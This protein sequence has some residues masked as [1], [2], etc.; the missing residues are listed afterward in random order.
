MGTP[1][2]AGADICKYIPQRKPIVMIDSFYG[3][4]EEQG[5]ATSV[6]GLTIGEDNLFVEDGQ[7]IDS[8]IIEHIAQ[9]G[10]M[11]IGYDS[12]SNGRPVPL[13][14]IGSVN[15]LTINR[16]PKVGETLNTTIV[17]EAQVGDIT[18]IGA[19]VKIGD[20]TIASGK[21]KVATK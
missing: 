10:A 11:Q 5:N 16:L 4:S 18:L 1:V 9:S 6:S 14:F 3:I 8:G 12:I 20:E 7:M 2:V 15:K 19:T 17:F 13:G 21:M